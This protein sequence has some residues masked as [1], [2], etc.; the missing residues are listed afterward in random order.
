MEKLTFLGSGAG[1]VQCLTGYPEAPSSHLAAPSEVCVLKRLARIFFCKKKIRK[2]DYPSSLL[3]F[4]QLND[5]MIQMIQNVLA[6]MPG[7]LS[8][9][10]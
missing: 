5:M 3:S 10:R 7:I 6:V 1:M 2:F 8:L 4:W 9:S